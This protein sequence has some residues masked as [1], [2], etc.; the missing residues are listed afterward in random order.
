MHLWAVMNKEANHEVE[1]EVVGWQRQAT[2]KCEHYLPFYSSICIFP[3]AQN[4]F[5]WQKSFFLYLLE[6]FWN[7]P[8]LPKLLVIQFLAFKSK[9]ASN[10]ASF[11]TCLKSKSFG[12][13]SWCLFIIWSFKESV[14]HSPPPQ[15]E[16]LACL[17][18]KHINL[19][20]LYVAHVYCHPF[21]QFACLLELVLLFCNSPTA[22]LHVLISVA[23]LYFS[24]LGRSSIE[25]QTK[26]WRKNQTTHRNDRSSTYHARHPCCEDAQGI[27][28]NCHRRSHAPHNYPKLSFHFSSVAALPFFFGDLRNNINNTYNYCQRNSE[29]STL[30]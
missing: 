28:G 24:F 22:F 19:L 15:L 25:Q 21:V 6:Q 12:H 20:L 8:L 11:Y 5:W 17:V 4:R 26:A 7:V 9:Q 30:E 13:Y 29:G 27:C 2:A 10:R 14:P 3:L 18:A 1:R 16:Q 23:S